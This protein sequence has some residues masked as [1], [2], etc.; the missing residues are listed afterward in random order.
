MENKEYRISEKYL[1]DALDKAS[2]TLVG[3]VMK[4]FEILDN[5]EEIKKVIKELIYENY[6]VLKAII[7]S[8][9]TGVKFITK[10]PRGQE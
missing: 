1:D 4:R 2:R 7:K 9:S 8:F 5:N 3:K 6:R 10:K